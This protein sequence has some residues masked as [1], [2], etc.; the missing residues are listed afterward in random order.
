MVKALNAYKAPPESHARGKGNS[1]GQLI[2]GATMEHLA[3]VVFGQLPLITPEPDMQEYCTHFQDVGQ[4]PGSP[5]KEKL[6]VSRAPTMAP[7]SVAPTPT[8]AP[9]LTLAPTHSDEVRHK[10]EIATREKQMR[11]HMQRQ[12]LDAMRQHGKV[13]RTPSSLA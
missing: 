3:H 5:C 12:Q 2:Q 1:H 6:I 13:R 10:Q 11:K 7:V 9:A 8:S 4:C